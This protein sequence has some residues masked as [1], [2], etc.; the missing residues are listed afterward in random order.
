MEVDW[1]TAWKRFSS[2]SLGQ[3]IIAIASLVYVSIFIFMLVVR[4]GTE[5]FYQA[6][7]NVYQMAP[8][9]FAGIC[10]V[11]LATRRHA[12]Q[13]SRVGWLFVGLGCLSFGT[14][15]GLWTYFESILGQ[16]VPFPGWPDVGYLGTYVFLIAG[17]AL[18]F[19]SSQVAGRGRLLMD[20]VIAASAFGMLSWYFLIG[21]LWESEVSLLG[22]TISVA[23]PLGDIAVLFMAIVTFNGLQRDRVTRRSMAL[24]AAGIV[25]VT[26]AD[27]IFTIYSLE[28]AYQTGSWVD[29]G[30]SFG[31]LLVAF[32]CLNKIWNDS[33][34]AVGESPTVSVRR[35]ALCLHLRAYG[36][37][38]AVF[39]A[40]T[41]TFG[42][43]YLTDGHLDLARHFEA[44]LLVGLLLIR[45]L[46]MLSENVGLTQR[47]RT[48]NDQLETRVEERTQQLKCMH[49]LARAVNSTLDVEQVLEVGVEH[50]I[51]LMG[52]DAV[53]IWLPKKASDPRRGLE[54]KRAVGFE[55]WEEALLILSGSIPFAG[56]S[57]VILNE[58]LGDGGD[59]SCLVVR[60]EW[61]H[62]QIGV[63]AA[64]RRNRLYEKGD[65]MLIEAVAVEL[66]C[67]LHNAVQHAAAVE[68]A[69]RDPV[70]GLLN[71][72]AFH[73]RL[74]AMLRTTPEGDGLSIM[75]LDLNN[76]KLFN[77]TYG[78]VQGD[79]VLK[80]VA[81]GLKAV[82][83]KASLKARYGGDEFVAA[84]PDLDG[85][86]AEA[87]AIRL[88]E[89]LSEQGFRRTADETKVP[90]T[91]SA[92]ISTF[93]ADGMTRHEL[94][95]VADNNLYTA[96]ASE[97][98]IV[99]STVQQRANRALRGEGSFE[100]LDALISAIDNKDRYTRKHSEEVTEYAL[101]I[102]E[103]LGLSEETQREIR[104]SGLLHDVGKIGVPE[105]ILR[106]PGGLTPE[107]FEIM[108]RHPR[109]GE[110]IVSAIPGMDR[111]VDGV[112]SHHE[113]W[114]GQGY[115]DQLAREE[116]P[117]LGRILGVADAFSAMTSD[118]PYR[119]GMGWEVAIGRIE[120][121][122]GTQFDP[123]M[124]EAFL[125]AVRK[126][127]TREYS[128]KALDAA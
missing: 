21:R 126:R 43:D 51:E 70:T 80:T 100:V 4:P 40:L 46:F 9:I 108:K 49:G 31:W 36:P 28:D 78:H 63:L 115:P 19:N 6:F 79:H 30:W 20:S 10:G 24:L 55:G 56:D 103:E 3:Q 75:M 53:A 12:S 119:K 14:G 116:I 124:A 89:Y 59:A 76:F 128:D 44:F 50:S 66:G 121:N 33:A 64:V 41:T 62:E 81:K 22:K 25:L 18:L 120:E 111:I 2:W 109:L 29:W 58:A 67:A 106:K 69:D 90:I 54:V 23:Y 123:T 87:V 77:D 92:G 113:R 83:P 71:H 42:A 107:E 45:Q 102:A 96:K 27:T 86:E 99:R 122:I 84:M 47:I 34:N 37:Y 5:Q 94:L 38:A 1:V 68:A 13:A 57:P 118:R 114:D 15:Q 61:Q 72:R 48:I 35:E 93:P 110:L 125:V 105:E 16:E 32:A 97:Q 74:Q 127:L 101:W 26:I 17:T 98:G 85:E 112:R 65:H 39:A 117:F 88:A 73:Q 8:P 82:C 104:M 91:V 11:I 60:V 52:A 7:H 95:S